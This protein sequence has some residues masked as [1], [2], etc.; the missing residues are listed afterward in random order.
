MEQLYIGI[1][2]IS[3]IFAGAT[4]LL[5]GR[6][7]KR[8]L[9]KYIPAMIAF[10]A[11]LALVIKTAMS[12]REGFESLGYAILAMIAA[13]IFLVSVITAITVEIVNRRRKRRQSES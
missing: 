1:A 8:V 13:V 12:A 3:L 6:R 10:A 11:T 2:L 4:I 7:I 9:L 5:G